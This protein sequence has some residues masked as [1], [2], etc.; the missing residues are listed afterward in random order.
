MGHVVVLMGVNVEACK[1]CGGLRV[2]LASAGGR[3]WRVRTQDAYLKQV[4]AVNSELWHKASRGARRAR[5]V[6]LAR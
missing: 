2:R 6:A 4:L 1:G 3:T 5:L